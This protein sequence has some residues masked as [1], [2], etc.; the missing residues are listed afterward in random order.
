MKKFI[1]TWGWYITIFGL[2]TLV[3]FG[4]YAAYIV[5]ISTQCSQMWKIIFVDTFAM[6]TG[7]M[8]VYFVKDDSDIPKIVTW[9]FYAFSIV[10]LGSMVYGIVRLL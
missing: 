6:A 8:M 7:I 5:A 10:C 4:F 3:A 2:F 9:Y 1:E